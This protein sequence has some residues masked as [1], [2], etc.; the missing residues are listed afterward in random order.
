LEKKARPTTEAH[1]HKGEAIVGKDQMS[2]RRTE[3]KFEESKGAE[4]EKRKKKKKL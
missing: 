1:K 3:G 2:K 4:K